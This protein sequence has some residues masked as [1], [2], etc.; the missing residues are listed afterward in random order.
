MGGWWHPSLTN[1][2]REKEEQVWEEGAE[3]KSGQA[4]TG[5]GHPGWET[6]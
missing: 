2:L 3:V 1:G 5:E 6:K 4:E